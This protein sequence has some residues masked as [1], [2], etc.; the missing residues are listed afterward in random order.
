M[1][2]S[3]LTQ[4]FTAPCSDV[5]DTRISEVDVT[6]TTFE[7]TEIMSS[8]LLALVVCD[9]SNLSAQQGDTLVNRRHPVY[10]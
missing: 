10:L 6:R 2:H 1:I 5:T 3:G 7:P 8:Y 9:Y 4:W